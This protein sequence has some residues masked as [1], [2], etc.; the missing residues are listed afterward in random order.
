MSK[1]RKS[2]LREEE[3]KMAKEFAEYVKE[4]LPEKCPVCG[5]PLD[6]DTI[7]GCAFCNGGDEVVKDYSVDDFCDVP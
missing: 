5:R 4:N 6:D 1:K 3:E 2:I 7:E